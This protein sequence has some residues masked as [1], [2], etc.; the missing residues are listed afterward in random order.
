MTNAL[1]LARRGLAS[2]LGKRLVALCAA[3]AVSLSLASCGGDGCNGY[4]CGGNVEVNPNLYSVDYGFGAFV[5]VGENSTIANSGD[6][7][8]YYV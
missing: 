8:N 5:A 4:G 7:G 1:R 6:G 2:P 3:V